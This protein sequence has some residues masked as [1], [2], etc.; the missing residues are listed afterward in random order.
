LSIYQKRGL[1]ASKKEEK[2]RERKKIK[3][4][5]QMSH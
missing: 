5:G 3:E 4:R 1:A 2:E